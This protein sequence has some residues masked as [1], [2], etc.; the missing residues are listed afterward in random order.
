[1]GLKDLGPGKAEGRVFGERETFLGESEER[2]TDVGAVREILLGT[3]S[4]RGRRK[5]RGLKEELPD[6]PLVQKVL[7]PPHP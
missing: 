5:E 4:Q 2:K 1:M 6:W 7:L 3:C